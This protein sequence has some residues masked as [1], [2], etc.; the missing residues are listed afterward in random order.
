[1]M[2]RK[3]LGIVV[4]LSGISFILFP[5]FKAQAQGEY[6]NR[7]IEIIVPYAPGGTVD[8]GIRFF[9][10]KW[11]EFLGQ[12]VIISNKS[13]AAGALG[14][15]YV[16]NAKPDGYTLL[17]A[18]DSPLIV[19]RLG[20]KEAGYD[21]DSFRILFFCARN[22]ELFFTVKADSKWKTLH[23]LL[24]EAK[25]NPGKIKYSTFGVG[26]AAHLVAEKLYKLAGVKMT[27]VPFQSTPESMTALIGGNVDMTVSNG[28]SGLAGSGL[29]RPVAVADEKRAI[30]FPEVPTLSE[31]GYAVGY[32]S[33]YLLLGAPSRVPEAF[34]SKWVEAHSKVL[35]KYGK[36]INEKIRKLE[37]YPGYVDGKS[38][39]QQL[40][41]KEKFYRDIVLQTGIQMQ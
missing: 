20:R 3:G 25:N 34:I 33:M 28:L 14:S 39:M 16:A 19:A 18:G 29:I 32:P 30:D 10:D 8:L 41:E 15:K 21:L 12:P 9:A 23:N 4:L 5:T 2:R 38:G 27:L 1:M 11:S 13:G 17:G 7:P 26:G 24:T 35:Q 40:R 6:P 22:A 37:M 36:E 31:L